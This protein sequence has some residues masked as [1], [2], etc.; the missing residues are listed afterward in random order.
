M[1]FTGRTETFLAKTLANANGFFPELSLGDFQK[2]YRVPANLAQETVEQQLINA[3]GEVNQALEERA[4]VWQAQGM[5]TLAEL[6]T[7]EGKTL[8]A[9]YFTAVY[10][11]AKAWLLRD[12]QT[13]SRRDVA[14]DSTQEGEDIYRALMVRSNAALRRL[15]GR[16]PHLTVELL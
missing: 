16:S 14:D 4:T 3:M 10:S 12:Y 13:F 6:A 15:E 7:A 8:V 5:G 11:R 9:F 1:S 2:Q